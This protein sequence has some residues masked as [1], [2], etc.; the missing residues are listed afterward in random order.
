MGATS[1]NPT[2]QDA[3][4]GGREAESDPQQRAE[5]ERFRE[6]AE[7][8]TGQD[9]E[10]AISGDLLQHITTRVTDEGLVIELHETDDGRL[11]DTDGGATDLLV[12]LAG[13]VRDA[14]TLVVNPVALEG[15]T[16]AYPKAM[17]RDPAWQVS[18]DRAHLFRTLLLGDGFDAGRVQRVTSHAD[19]EPASAAPMDLRNNRLE[20]V[21][22]RRF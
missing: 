9:D 11:F 5:E 2:E 16:A 22:L 21:F 10:A 13:I 12:R 17:A 14:A 7:Q 20:I 18:N 3:A 8:L 1:R 19:R 15:H 6:L 4:S